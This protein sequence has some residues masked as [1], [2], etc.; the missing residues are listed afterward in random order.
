MEHE[1]QA[2]GAVQLL[3]AFLTA[4]FVAHQR[5]H[6]NGKYKDEY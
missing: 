6:P 3:P 1:H 5:N 2:Q 4:F